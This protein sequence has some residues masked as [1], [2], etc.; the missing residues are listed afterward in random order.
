MSNP[1]IR[2]SDKDG[3][4]SGTRWFDGAFPDFNVH[5]KSGAETLVDRVFAR[6]GHDPDLP[7]IDR[8]IYVGCG[9]GSFL[10]SLIRRFQ[11]HDA[12]KNRELKIR[13]IYLCEKCKDEALQAHDSQLRDV[14]MSWNSD[15]LQALEAIPQDEWPRAAVVLVGHAWF[16]WDQE[17]TIAAIK[18][19]RPAILLIDVRQKWDHA[20]SHLPYEEGYATGCMIANLNP[21]SSRFTVRIEPIDANWVTRSIYSDDELLFQTREARVTIYDL[22]GLI[23][24]APGDSFLCLN[25]CREAGTLTGPNGADYVCRRQIAHESGWGMMDCYAF[26]PRD[27]TAIVLN[28]AFFQVLKSFIHDTIQQPEESDRSLYVNHGGAKGSS[29][30]AYSPSPIKQLLRM[31]DEPALLDVEE[32]GEITG[33]RMAVAILPFDFNLTFVRFIPLF[34]T[35][36]CEVSEVD[37]LAE[38]PCPVQQRFPSAYGIYQTLLSRSSCPQAFTLRWARD[39]DQTL[40][41]RALRILEESAIGITAL[42]E[43]ETRL[44]ESLIDEANPPSFFMVPIYFG[45]L[46]LF[47]LALKFPPLFDPASTGFDVYLSTVGNLHSAIAVQL[48]DD[49][50]RIRIVRPW[51]EHCLSAEWPFRKGYE[52]VDHKLGVLEEYL[53]GRRICAGNPQSTRSGYTLGDS[54]WEGGVLSKEWK[55]WILGLPSFPINEMSSVIEQ[56]RRLWRIWNR[57]RTIARMD[58]ALRISLW[59]QDGMFFE[60]AQRHDSLCCEYHLVSLQEMF[61]VLNYSYG[62]SGNEDFRLSDAVDWLKGKSEEGGSNQVLKYFG[63]TTVK[64]FL[65]KWL[66]KQLRTLDVLMQTCM[67]RSVSA[68]PCNCPADPFKKL[69]AVFCKSNANTGEK[70]RFSLDRLYYM[71]DAARFV[72]DNQVGTIDADGKELLE[73]SNLYLPEAFQATFFSDEDPT[74]LIAEFTHCLASM[75]NPN[76]ND[77]ECRV[78]NKVKLEKAEECGGLA[79]LCVQLELSMQL[80]RMRGGGES[81]SLSTLAE[82]I[83][84]HCKMPAL[85]YHDCDVV[86]IY[87]QMD[88]YGKTLPIEEAF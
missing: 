88:K 54:R 71:L 56:N 52:G 83:R 15:P 4:L 28:D 25:A 61:R 43:A 82:K 72:A 41:D 80:T 47:A 22:F 39:Y 48:T 31:F 63:R 58:A 51:I 84:I 10:L 30:G 55:S 78:L 44:G 12:C 42:R 23:R 66:L 76:G 77:P 36:S 62:Q 26:V 86:N 32:D 45:S 27:P 33:C 85:N 75:T 40:A 74:L 18:K 46:P 38:Y 1:C 21:S 65:F 49:L 16:Q 17:L 69:K 20:L 9:N 14:E 19:H 11:A 50:V 70:I 73:D 53:F 68:E 87:F 81:H 13:A 59:F 34:R 37:Q 35:L 29:G 24:D 57:E 5:E 64:H 3:V 67:R 79:Q 7:H 6:C 2:H 8:I 60:D